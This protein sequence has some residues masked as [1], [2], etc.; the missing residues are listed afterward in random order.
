MNIKKISGSVVFALI[1]MA[2]PVQVQAVDS[3]W[4]ALYDQA[5]SLYSLGRYDRAEILALDSLKLAQ[6]QDGKNS[7]AA[8]RSLGLL[9]QTYIAQDR[10]DE[11]EQAAKQSLNIVEKVAGKNN[12]AGISALITLALVEQ[13]RQKF[14]EAEKWAKNALS[15]A[16]A[17][18]SQEVAYAL[19]VLGLIYQ[20]HDKYDQAEAVLKRSLALYQQFGTDTLEVIATLG[21]VYERNGKCIDAQ[22]LLTKALADSKK[23]APDVRYSIIVAL[24]GCAEFDARWSE[25]EKMRKD[26]LDKARGGNRPR[27]LVYALSNLSS[28]YQIQDRYVEA[29]ALSDEAL[30]IATKTGDRLSEAT[31]KLELASVN[32]FLGNYLAAETLARGS[33]TLRE[34]LFGPN[35]SLVLEAN[36]ELAAALRE[37]KRSVEAMK[38]YQELLPAYEKLY[39]VSDWGVAPIHIAIGRLHYLAQ[40]FGEAESAYTRARRMLESQFG[41]ENFRLAPVFTGLADVFRGQGKDV[42]AERLYKLSLNIAERTYGSKSSRLVANLIGLAAIS[43]KRGNVSEAEQ[44]LQRA[45]S[46]CESSVGANHPYAASA[47][48]ELAIIYEKTNRKTDAAGALK[49]V[50]QIEEMK[51]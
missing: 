51:R 8:G 34:H 31:S 33:R 1:V 29:M 37:Q 3:E 40:R 46:I 35:D 16:E 48:K 24:A 47:L 26:L 7:I 14:A 45:L 25:A 4:K 12:Q 15:V 17:S 19:L 38:I 6:A 20:R 36:G 21:L 2:L 23:V 27:Q 42:E 50:R 5:S 18:R 43:A 10:T 28:L 49:R 11:A 39:G 41:T 13:N 32:F 9:S 44:L 22:P 30:S